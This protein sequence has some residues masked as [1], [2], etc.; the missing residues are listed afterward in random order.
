MRSKTKLRAIVAGAVACLSLA[1]PVHAQSA[2]DHGHPSAP[3]HKP[4]HG[5]KLY[6]QV[7]VEQLEYRF[8]NG[9]DV[10]NWDAQAWYGGDYEKIRLK[11]EG[12]LRPSD[13]VE[14]AEV[15]LLY[16]RLVAYYWDIQAGVR[17]DFR[18][19]PSR[20]Y[21]VIGLQGLAPGYFE[22]DLNGFVS[23]EGDF[24]GRLKAEYDLLI[25]QRLILQPKVEINIA[26][27]DVPELGIGQGLNDVE[28][29]L[30]LRYEIVRE[31]APY[32]GVTWHRKLGETANFARREGEDVDEFAMLAGVRFWF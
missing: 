24:S 2:P 30:R 28:L 7:L 1:A 23:E 18:P 8:Q 31:F 22:V 19:E 13:G 11:T 5:A 12:A 21:G 9:K 6:G 4:E 17:H 15:Q 27:Q 14:D 10:M 3:A 26:A 16:A 25:T 32:I 29:G 20:S